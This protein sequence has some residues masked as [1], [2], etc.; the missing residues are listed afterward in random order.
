VTVHNLKTAGSSCHLCGSGQFAVKPLVLQFNGSRYAVPACE[1]CRGL[2]Y[3]GDP[4][5][6]AQQADRQAD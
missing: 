6:L 2:L 1:T 4:E 5:G 3:Y